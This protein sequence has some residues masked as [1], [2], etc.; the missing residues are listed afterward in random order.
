M[1]LS[2]IAML[3][4]LRLPHHTIF[5]S[6]V[7]GCFFEITEGVLLLLTGLRRWGWSWSRDDVGQAEQLTSAVVTRHVTAVGQSESDLPLL[8]LSELQ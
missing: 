2:I 7:M 3:R 5:P 6:L 4:R 8:L 1:L